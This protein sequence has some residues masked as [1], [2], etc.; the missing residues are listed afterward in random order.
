VKLLLD[1]DISFR[2]VGTIVAAFP[3]S[4]HLRDVGLMQAD[5]MAIWRYAKDQGYAIVTL[6]SDVY[7]ISL[8]RGWPPKIIWLKP[9]DTASATITLAVLGH[10]SEIASFLAAPAAACLILR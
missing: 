10:V 8:V 9:P 7:D 4:A 2:V 3:G 5:D 1:A 6:D